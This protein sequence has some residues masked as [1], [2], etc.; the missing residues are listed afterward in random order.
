MLLYEII[1]TDPMTYGDSEA[2]E[3]GN[4]DDDGVDSQ[5]HRNGERIECE[6]TDELK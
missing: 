5:A 1:G 3:G 2:A 4:D 6:K